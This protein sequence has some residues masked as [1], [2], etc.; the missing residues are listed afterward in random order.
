MLKKSKV[1]K[2]IRNEM[3][4][5][6]D[7]LLVAEY[8]AGMRSPQTL[9]NWRRDHPRVDRYILKCLSLCEDKRVALVEDAQFK[10][11]MSGS[12]KAQETFLFNRAPGRWKSP[13]GINNTIYNV[14]TK[15]DEETADRFQEAP[16][17]IFTDAKE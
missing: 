11:A 2:I 15:K 14:N 8:R 6:G 5:K 17:F 1:L 13:I 7:L 9:L 10:S 3:T 16:R 4:E 12:V